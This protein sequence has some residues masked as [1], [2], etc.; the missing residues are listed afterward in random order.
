MQLAGSV[1]RWR[2][3]AMRFFFT[4]LFDGGHAIGAAADEG[5]GRA[6]EEGLAQWTQSSAV[7]ARRGDILDRNGRVLAQSA[8]AY[9]V[10]AVP[11]QVTNPEGFAKMLA[12]LLNLKEA[13]I[14]TRFTDITKG[15]V[16]LKRQ[17]TRELYGRLTPL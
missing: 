9:N 13:T 4:L 3:L 2:M 17:V 8:T 10:S 14:L 12:P 5:R 7:T 16:T 15:R 1:I 11:R 6:V